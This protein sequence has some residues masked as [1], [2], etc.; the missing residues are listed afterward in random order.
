MCRQAKQNGSKNIPDHEYAK[1]TSNTGLRA[2]IRKYHAKAY[3]EACEK[4]GWDIVIAELQK[5]P[6][7]TQLDPHLRPGVK[8]GDRKRFTGENFLNA[9]VD[10]IAADDQVST[11]TPYCTVAPI[12]MGKQVNQR[13]RVQRVSSP[14]PLDEG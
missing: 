3:V 13:C 8:K 7:Q 14:T 2:H 5:K 6:T 12:L 4:N 1:G 10:F 11:I 9:L